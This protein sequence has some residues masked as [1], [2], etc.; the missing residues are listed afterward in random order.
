M[1]L[2][3]KTWNDITVAR[4]RDIIA[5]SGDDTTEEG[6]ITTSIDTLAYLCGSTREEVELLPI[7]EFTRL[8]AEASFLRKIDEE[9]IDED[10]VING[11]SYDLVTDMDKFIVAQYIDWNS[12]GHD[13]KN[14][15]ARLLA[16]ILIPRG[17]QYGKGYDIEDVVKDINDKLPFLK[18]LAMFRFFEAAQ[19]NIIADTLR[20]MS[21]M[22]RVEI[23]K[24]R[25]KK[26][27]EELRK[28]QKIVHALLHYHGWN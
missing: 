20:K 12:L 14:N 4:Y 24:T 3:Y 10:I 28:E 6:T 19:R 1:K 5:L 18:A 21:K 9:V 15:L 2:L 16:C 7:E 26:R 22:A 27:R 23:L 17:H 13:P 25:D 8:M 11:K